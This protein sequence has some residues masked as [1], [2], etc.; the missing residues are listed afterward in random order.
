M[1][2]KRLPAIQELKARPDISKYFE[3][4][5]STTDHYVDEWAETGWTGLINLDLI[6]SYGIED[7]AS[8]IHIAADQNIAFTVLGDIVKK[9]EF[10]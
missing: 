2:E 9:Y 7:G 5:L 4:P 3:E 10:L 6:L 1:L 8:D